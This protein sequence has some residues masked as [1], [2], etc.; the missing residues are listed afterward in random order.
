MNRYIIEIPGNNRIKIHLKGDRY[1]Y[2]YRLKRSH[3][4]CRR[5]AFGHEPRG[6]AERGGV[7]PRGR[8]AG[9]PLKTVFERV[10]AK[11]GRKPNSIRN[12]YYARVKESGRAA[13]EALHSAAFV[14]FSEE[15][16]RMLMRTVLTEQ[17]KGVSVRAC[18][19]AMG[20]G[21]TK[22]MLRYQNKYRSLLRTNPAFVKK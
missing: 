4:A 10:A 11:T 22:T 7:L 12:Y 21:D 15:E 2:G 13:S 9:L 6:L 1:E 19:L 17:A 5:A 14:P 8:A 20:K 18:T 3:A 16:M